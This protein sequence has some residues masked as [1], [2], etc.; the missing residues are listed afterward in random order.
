MPGLHS[1]VHSK[2]GSCT[3]AFASILPI[4]SASGIYAKRDVACLRPAQ[5]MI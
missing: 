2:Q 4:C 1:Y 5:L 3:P